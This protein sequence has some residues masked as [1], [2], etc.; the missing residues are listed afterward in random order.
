MGFV[1]GIVVIGLAAVA[2]FLLAPDRVRADD[3][4]IIHYADGSSQRIR[5]ERPSESI[6]QI[7]FSQPRGGV[8][9]GEWSPTQIRVLS[10][11]YGGNCGAPFG[12]A[13]DHL[14]AACDGSPAC[15]YVIDYHALGDPAP[16]CSKDYVAEW[17][18]GRSPQRFRTAAGPEAGMGKRIVLRCPGR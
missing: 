12:N 13:T 15:D 5:L 10:G 4:L 3:F 14:I 18:C 2:L 6:R 1:K 11:T 17:Q 8:G 7:E 9:R 16:G